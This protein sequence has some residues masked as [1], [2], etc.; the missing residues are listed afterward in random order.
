MSL[1]DTS[2]ALVALALN[3]DLGSGDITSNALIDSQQK[4]EAVF[5]AREDFVLCG[6]EVVAEVCKQVDSRLTFERLAQDGETVK[7]DQK[8]GV[9]RGS[10]KSI[11]AA[12]RTA[13]NFLQRLSGVATTTKKI[14][15]LV[16][17]SGVRVLD[18]RKTTAGARTLEKYAVR[19]GGGHNHR[20]GL[21]DAVLIKNNHLDAFAGTP[22]EA[23]RTARSKAPK[24]TKIEIEVRNTAELSSALEGQPDAILLDN[25]TPVQISEAVK[26]VRAQAGGDK[27]ELEASGGINADNIKNYLNTGINS[28]SLGALTHSAKGVDISLWITI[29][30]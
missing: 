26:L 9:L 6:Q 3:E 14:A 13:L 20:S 2:R 27:I 19:A 22:A 8:L 23:V 18:T 16:E 5:V 1:D 15:D 11:L 12:E 17:G 29:N 21:Y 25:M 4:A 10:A 28:I 24:G 30:K 7:R